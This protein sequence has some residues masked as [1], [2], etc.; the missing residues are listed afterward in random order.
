LIIVYCSIHHSSL[1][2]SDD[3][4]LP[5]RAL[6]RSTILLQIALSFVADTVPVE[7]RP[8]FMGRLSA[9][10]GLGFVAGP[11]VVVALTKILHFD[12]KV[13]VEAGVAIGAV[14]LV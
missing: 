12:T 9:M 13:R 10:V 7:D 5:R 14:W 11:T 2:G 1:L 8:R 3:L 4:T 6:P